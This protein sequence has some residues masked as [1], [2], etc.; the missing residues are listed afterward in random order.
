MRPPILSHD[1]E[2]NIRSILRN[3]FVVGGTR[4]RRLRSCMRPPISGHDDEYCYIP[5]FE[6][7]WWISLSMGGVKKSGL[8]HHQSLFSRPTYV[9]THMCAT[10]NLEPWRWNIVSVRNCLLGIRI[11]IKSRQGWVN[12]SGTVNL[13]SLFSRPVYGEKRAVC[14]RN[15]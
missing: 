14:K 6:I 13:K 2:W 4:E 3:C 1:D 15:L 11:V 7:A 8:M 10:S 9:H 12:R 5:F